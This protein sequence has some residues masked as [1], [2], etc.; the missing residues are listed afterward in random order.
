MKSHIRKLSTIVCVLLT[1]VCLMF[2][3]GCGSARHDADGISLQTPM[4]LEF[5]KVGSPLGPIDIRSGQLIV[6]PSCCPPVELRDSKGNVVRKLEF[7]RKPQKLVADP[8]RYAIVGHAPTVGEHVLI[9]Q[10]R[11]E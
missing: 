10:V 6:L 2:G 5:G 8:G 11:E 7:T 3:A 1:F 4:V 9:I